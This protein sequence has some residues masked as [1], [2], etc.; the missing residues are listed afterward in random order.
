MAQPLW[1]ILQ[2]M[3]LSLPY[4]PP[5]HSDI[6]LKMIKPHVHPKACMPVFIA[7]LFIRDVS[8]DGK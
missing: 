2:K 3:D 8:H 4:D 6:Y 5:L 1:K 7:A